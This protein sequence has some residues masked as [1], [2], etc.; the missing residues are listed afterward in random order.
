[1]SLCRISR[2]DGYTLLGWY[3]DLSSDV[4]WDFDRD[5]VTAVPVTLYAKFERQEPDVSFNA[6]GADSGTLTNLK[7]GMA[8]SLDGGGSW[9]VVSGTSVRLTGLKAGDS[10]WVRHDAAYNPLVTESAVKK[11]TI[12]QAAVPAGW[13]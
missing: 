2:A 5:T 13:S 10:L 8:Y 3:Q 6:D 12:A 1:M 4:P 9:T 7:P 11:I